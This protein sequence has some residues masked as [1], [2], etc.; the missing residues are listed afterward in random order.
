MK[1][2]SKAEPDGQLPS[3]CRACEA[4]HKGICGVLTPAELQSLNRHSSQKE[5]ARGTTLV[6]DGETNEHY[7]NILSGVV[8][9]TK[10]LQDGREQIVGLQFAPDFL[11]RA[12]AEESPV[13]AETASDVKLCRF[14]KAAIDRMMGEV[15]ELQHRMFEQVLSQL[16]EARD[17]ILTL[18]RK[19]ATEKVASFLLLIAS[20][21]QPLRGTL[22]DGEPLTFELPLSRADI[23]DYLGLTLETVS[24]QMT[25][26]R[27]SGAIEIA[28][29][30]TI[31]IVDNNR[32]VALSGGG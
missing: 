24:R 13:T 32:L 3:L 26:L 31:T 22:D 7:A 14:P 17:W 15:P 27:Q 8:K 6:S 5:Y 9:L 25:K 21:I 19:S 23:A 18:G 29:N 12:M 1:D 4:R 20:H 2:D 10:T 28:H 16:D 11:G 30:R